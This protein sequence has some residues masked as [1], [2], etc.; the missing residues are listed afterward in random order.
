MSVHTRAQTSPRTSERGVLSTPQTT[1][2]NRSD[3]LSFQAH[4]E[5]TVSKVLPAIVAI[6]SSP[7]PQRDQDYKPG[8]RPASGSGVIITSDGVILSQSHV[9]HGPAEETGEK[10]PR[11]RPGELVSVFLSDG[12]ERAA[13]LL[14]ADQALT[15]GESAVRTLSRIAGVSGPTV[16]VILDE[17][18][19]EVSLG[20]TVDVA[21]WVMAP[22]S[23]FLRN[24]VVAS[25]THASCQLGSSGSAAS[26][27]W[28][29]EGES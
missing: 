1:L 21:G 3:L 12:S 27:T 6:R 9:S 11:R 28:R 7:R 8:L 16:V 19:N 18:K 10:K 26:T 22:A 14:G 17:A 13:E 29:F 20:T 5:A 25:R 4:I 23:T 2:A 15:Q 24:L